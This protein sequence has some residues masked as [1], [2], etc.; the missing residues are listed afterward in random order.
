MLRSMPRCGSS[1]GNGSIMEMKVARRE[2]NRDEGGGVDGAE[3]MREERAGGA[4]KTDKQTESVS[5]PTLP[6]VRLS[7]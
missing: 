3:G 2:A 4:G 6:C 1:N 5:P 7:V